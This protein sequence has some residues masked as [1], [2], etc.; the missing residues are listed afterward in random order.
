MAEKNLNTRFQQKHDSAANWAKAANFKPLE[1]EF[2]IYDANS[3]H[4]VPRIKVGNGGTNVEELPF[5]FENFTEAEIINLLTNKV[6]LSIDESGVIYNGGLGY[7]NGYRVRSGGT[8]QET[9][10]GACTGYIEVKAGD[11]VRVSGMPWF[12]GTSS[13]NALNVANAAFTNLG[14][15]TTGQGATYGIF[16]EN[17]SQYAGSSVVEEKTG[18][19]KWVVPAG[20]NIAYIRISAIDPTSATTGKDLV[21]TINQGG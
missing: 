12:T 13:A 10:Y 20:A 9:Q 8:E 7:K 6:A 18:V 2:I 5:F 21:V 4:T 3:A 19:W 17:F 15:F 16:A 14:Q 1:G 11:I